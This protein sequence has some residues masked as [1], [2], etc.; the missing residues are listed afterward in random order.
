MEN[1]STAVSVDR[2]PDSLGD[3]LSAEVARRIVEL[4]ADPDIQLRIEELAERSGGGSLAAAECA[5]YGGYLEG[6]DILSLIKLKTYR[7]L[8]TGS[9]GTP[10]GRP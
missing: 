4:R 2:I 10:T 9:G 8:V 6:A 7:Y 3:S 1:C 5:E